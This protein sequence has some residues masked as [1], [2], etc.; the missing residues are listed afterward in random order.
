MHY[1]W[2]CNEILNSEEFQGMEIFA[3]V[4]EFARRE[5]N[6]HCVSREN[7]LENADQV[8]SR[9]LLN[10]D[11]PGI[12]EFYVDDEEV[13]TI[14]MDD[15]FRKNAVQEILKMQKCEADRRF[16]IATLRHQLR[17][18]AYLLRKFCPAEY[19]DIVNC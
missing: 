16:I 5:L 1:G 2:V 18:P 7:P 12:T 13:I 9:I 19:L 10:S 8:I 15:G 6:A 14:I 4:R 17:V 3:K 11:K